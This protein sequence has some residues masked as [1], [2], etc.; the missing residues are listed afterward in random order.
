MK[1][2]R[3]ILV[4]NINI[5]INDNNI[6]Q[7]DLAK[8]IGTH[9]SRL[10]ECLNKKKDFTLPQV[11][12][13]ADYFKISIDDLLNRPSRTISAPDTLSEL[14]EYFFAL[15]DTLDFD[16]SYQDVKFDKISADSRNKLTRDDNKLTHYE[17]KGMFYDKKHPLHYSVLSLSLINEPF[18][19]FLDEWQSARS[20]LKFSNG[21]ELYE[22]WKKG[23]LAK[24]KNNLK[25][26]QYRTETQYIDELIR[27]KYEYCFD[28]MESEGYEGYSNFTDD[29]PLKAEWKKFSKE[30]NQSCSDR[31]RKFLEQYEE[32]FN[33]WGMLPHIPNSALF[34]AGIH[35]EITV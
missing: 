27:K 3:A 30:F 7:S 10:S 16:I 24:Y 18:L 1:Y 22:T 4:D 26:Y 23:I 34:Q 9:Q 33:N 11:V 31:E 8:I 20:L 13:I 5:L 19:A 25:T 14:C 6:T 29:S 12:A 15:T 35:M 21:F 2:D 17:I 28:S 32:A